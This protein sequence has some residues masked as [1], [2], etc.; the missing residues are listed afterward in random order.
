MTGDWEQLGEEEEEEEEEERGGGNRDED[1][2]DEE[3]DEEEVRLL[4]CDKH[5]ISCDVQDEEDDDHSGSGIP[6]V[7]FIM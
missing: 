2:E 1:E 6:E 3:E 7:R 4:S 5:V